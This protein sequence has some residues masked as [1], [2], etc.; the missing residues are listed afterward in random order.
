MFAPPWWRVDRWLAWIL[1]LR[2]HAGTADILLAN[3]ERE[4]DNGVHTVRV[5][6]EVRT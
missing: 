2:H 4:Q 6:A 5:V 3:Q 1:W